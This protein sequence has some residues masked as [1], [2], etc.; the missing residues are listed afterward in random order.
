DPQLLVGMMDATSDSVGRVFN[1]SVDDGLTEKP[2]TETVAGTHGLETRATSEEQ[3]AD[4]PLAAL[5][6]WV[7]DPHNR[8]FA[9][10]QVNRIWAELFGR[11]LVEP[12]DDF[13]GTNPATH[14]ALLEW[15]TDDF[16]AHGY[17][18]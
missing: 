18:M 15:L 5:A 1:P 13:R 12:V 11:G 16:I 4:D 8:Q 7:A 14:P 3:L 6:D 2:E 10:V 17:D 9:R